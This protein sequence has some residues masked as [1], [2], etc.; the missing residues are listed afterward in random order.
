MRNMSSVDK[1]LQVL[2]LLG[3]ESDPIGVRE[4]GRRLSMSPPTVHRLLAT[5][6]SYDLVAQVEGRSE[7]RLGLACLDLGRAALGGTELARVAPQIAERLRDETE[8]TV[9]VQVP[10][11]D[12][13]VCVVEAE[14]LHELRR[15]VGV[16]RRVPL[17]AGA[18]GRAILAF[19]PEA[20]IERYLVGPLA[21]VGP[22]T[23]TDAE[24]LRAR[25]EETRRKGYAMSHQ[26]TV[27]GVA[28]ASVPIFGE[29]AQVAG[30]MSVSG[31]EA[32]MGPD[33]ETRIVPL[34]VE[35]GRSLSSKL[36]FRGPKTP[37]SSSLATI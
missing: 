32:R 1:A 9:T 37:N 20:E 30:S 33:L 4:I 14:G 25:L 27:V 5:L 18:S 21:E 15:R 31:P 12:E 16:G 26:E 34:L 7:Y 6:A 29:D 19:L 10:V 17:H 11:G 28:A 2:L 22:N 23:L 24:R 8:E 36:G 13:Q 3:R 35:A